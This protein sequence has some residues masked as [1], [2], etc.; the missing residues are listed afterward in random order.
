MKLTGNTPNLFVSDIARSLAFYRDVLGF[1]VSTT[2]PEAPPFVFAWLQRDGV[3]V[4]LNDT[5]AALRE[6]PELGVQAGHSGVSLFIQ[7]EGI[8][9]LWALVRTQT[10]VVMALKDQWYGMTEFTIRDPDGYLVTFAEHT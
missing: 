5:A 8:K 3:A 10:P 9:D 2:V 1:T 4:F 6:S 7:M